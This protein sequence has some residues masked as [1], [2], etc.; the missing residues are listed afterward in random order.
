L[1]PAGKESVENHGFEFVDRTGAAAAPHRPTRPVVI[2]KEAIEAEAARLAG[3]PRPSNG[4]RVSEIVNSDAGIGNGLAPGIAA[5]LC[6]LNPGERTEPRRHNSSVV[7]FCLSGGGRSMIAGKAVRFGQYDVWNT[8]SWAVYEHIND[9]DE[10]QVR[11]AYSNASLLE[12]MNV[13]VVEDGL[14]AAP[15]P[16]DDVRRGASEDEDKQPNPFG[17]FQLTDDGAYLMPYESL[18][19][20]DVVRVPP[21]HWPWTLVKA[22][23]DKLTA[24]GPSYRGR[25]LYLLY[26]PATGRANGTSLS[27]FATMCV[28]PAGIKDRPHRHTAAA[29]NYFFQGR[30]D[31]IVEG[32]KYPWKAGDLMLTA[33]GWAIHRHA[34]HDE[35]VYELTIQDSPLNIVMGS[36]L[37]Q[38]HLDRPAEALGLTGGFDTNRAE[39]SRS[40]LNAG[41]KGDLP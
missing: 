11:L 12:K 20:P 25:R 13:H 27:F 29:I 24:L 5:S 17:T 37:W 8:P 26:H 15:P 35:D 18:I 4:H 41:T 7:N 21:L 16:S 31:S 19:S 39:A 34:S 28:R 1:A 6:V 22:E 23:L 3:L 9:T 36:L 14:E 40:P 30:G 10:V 2:P 32:E 33:P 38:E